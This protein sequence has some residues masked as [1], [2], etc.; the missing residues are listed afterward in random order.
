MN[1]SLRDWFA[2]QAMIGM[3]ISQGKNGMDCGHETEYNGLRYPDGIITG[4]AMGIAE[5]AYAL[6][7]AA[8][9]TR[10]TPDGKYPDACHHGEKLAKRLLNQVRE[11][12]WP[13]GYEPVPSITE[14]EHTSPLENA[15]GSRILKDAR[16]IGG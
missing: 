13:D 7:D 12:H 11:D 10:L 14:A 2:G 9:G 8:L 16:E 6:A 5:D 3:I 4:L 1:V 15:K